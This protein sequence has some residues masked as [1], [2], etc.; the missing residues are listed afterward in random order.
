MV[1]ASA[2]PPEVSK[3]SADPHI[4]DDG[5]DDVIN[6]VP[7]IVRFG[8]VVLFV[9]LLVCRGGVN[10]VAKGMVEVDNEG[11]VDSQDAPPRSP[12]KEVA[13]EVVLF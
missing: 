6:P 12:N 4:N 2:P 13:V 1:D 5:D 7:L 3:L 8:V 10:V 11:L 9:V